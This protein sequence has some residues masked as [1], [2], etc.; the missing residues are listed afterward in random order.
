ME[1]YGPAILRVMVGAMFMAHGAQKLFGVFGGAGLSGTAAGFDATGLSPGF[2]LA[3]A[4]GLSEFGC[5][6]LL[7]AGAWT[8]F[9]AV[10]LIIV[11]LGA[12]WNVHLEH[13]F[14]INWALTPGVGHGVEYNLLILA[15]LLSLIL[16]GPGALSIDH[17]RLRSAESY[18]M[19]RARLRG[20]Y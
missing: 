1:S 7:I 6:L 5:G 2:P 19:G 10:P 3:V 9:A 17:S 20:K 8:R 15:S 12:M 16:T 14:F 13:G 4:V 18:A 11:M